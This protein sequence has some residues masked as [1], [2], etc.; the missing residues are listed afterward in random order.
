[1]IM[2][3][4]VWNFTKKNLL[5]MVRSWDEPS[6]VWSVGPCEPRLDVKSEVDES[7]ELS[8]ATIQTIATLKFESI[9]N[10]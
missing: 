9:Q 7:D 5:L 6:G 4:L 10:I 3:L 8:F 2:M 1:M